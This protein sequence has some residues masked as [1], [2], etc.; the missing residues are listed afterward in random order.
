MDKIVWT[1]VWQATLFKNEEYV[2][3][4]AG[5]RLLVDDQCLMPEEHQLEWAFR[6]IIGML[7]GFGL[8]TLSVIPIEKP[9]P[10]E[11]KWLYIVRAGFVQWA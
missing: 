4:F 9:S 6:L 1:K 7:G 10:L 5:Y 3:M 11:P 2:I 8:S